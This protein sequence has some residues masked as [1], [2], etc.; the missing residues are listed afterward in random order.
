MDSTP[1]VP[2]AAV[3]KDN[4]TV[5]SILGK[6]LIARLIYDRV[7]LLIVCGQLGVDEEPEELIKRLLCDAVR[8]FVKLEPHKWSKK[9]LKRWR[10]ICSVSTL[11]SATERALYTTRTKLLISMWDRVPSKP[12]MGATDDD[13]EKLADN[14][15][16]LL[17]K[18][19]LLDSDVSG[20]DWRRRKWQAFARVYATYMW[21]DINP[22]SDLGVATWNREVCATNTV[23]SFTN[24]QLVKLTH[25]GI[26]LSGRYIT[27]YGNSEERTLGSCLV[28][29][30]NIAMGDDCTETLNGIE[31]DEVIRRYDSMG[32]EG[33]VEYN[34]TNTV[35]GTIFCSLKFYEKEDGSYSAEPV[36]WH[37]TLYRLI[38]K[39][40]KRVPWGEVAQFEY[41]T[42]NLR[43]DKGELLRELRLKYL[44]ESLV[45]A[46]Q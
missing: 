20:W 17:A 39:G 42:R 29:T 26:M 45:P 9:V 44:D 46:D 6:D 25:G 13:L 4:M 8:V 34:L 12:G 33:V 40:I 5:I 24:G 11:D 7:N 22:N 28:G 14:L 1:G 37:R 32:Y 3:G 2:L 35:E 16:D 19:E 36:H 27:S 38:S 15:K 10:L 30:I 18:G 21:W 41:E 23:F 31:L 43:I